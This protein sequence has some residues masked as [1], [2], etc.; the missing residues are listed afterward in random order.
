MGLRNVLGLLFPDDF[1]PCFPDFRAL[2]RLTRKIVSSFVSPKSILV[3]RF[4]LLVVSLT[5]GSGLPLKRWSIHFLKGRGAIRFVCSSPSRVP[6]SEGVSVATRCVSRHTIN[7]VGRRWGPTL[8]SKPSLCKVD[9]SVY[10]KNGCCVAKGRLEEVMK[11]LF[12]VIWARKA[13]LKRLSEERYSRALP[14]FFLLAASV[15]KILQIPRPS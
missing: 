1:A 6:G 9:R 15:V 2:V 13:M 14:C 8:G 10:P 7:T 3:F 11:G 12:H 5:T 4:Q